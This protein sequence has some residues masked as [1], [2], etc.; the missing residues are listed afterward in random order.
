MVINMFWHLRNSPKYKWTFLKINIDIFNMYDI[1]GN[2]LF[3]GPALNY[4]V[5]DESL[6]ITTVR[7]YNSFSNKKSSEF[8]ALEEELYT[9]YRLHF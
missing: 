9:F 5:S 1:K 4:N 6:W 2:S 8:H 7:F 3:W